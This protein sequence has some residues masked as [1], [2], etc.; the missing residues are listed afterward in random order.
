[1]IGAHGGDMAWPVSGAAQ[2]PAVHI[3]RPFQLAHAGG[4]GFLQQNAAVHAMKRRVGIRKIGCRCRPGRSRAQQGVGDGVQ[5]RVGVRVAHKSLSCGMVTRPES[6]DAL[7]Q[8]VNVPNFV[9]WIIL[10]VSLCVRSP[11]PRSAR[12]RPA[13]YPGDRVTLSCWRR[14]APGGGSA[15]ALDGGC[16]VGD[17]GAAAAPRRDGRPWRNICRVCVCHRSSHGGGPTPVP[18]SWRLRE[19]STR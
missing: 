6:G 17:V 9:Q 1:M 15:Q 11:G 16:L 12:R 5:E 13:G 19:I 3:S 7:H 8:F 4:G 2:S 14:C 18:C 10:P